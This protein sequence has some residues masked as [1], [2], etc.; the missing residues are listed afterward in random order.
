MA[1]STDLWSS[2]SV[3]GVALI[4]QDSSPGA[5]FVLFKLHRKRMLKGDVPEMGWVLEAN[6]IF[7]LLGNFSKKKRHIQRDFKRENLQLPT[8]ASAWISGP[9]DLWQRL[10]ARP[11]PPG[12]VQRDFEPLII[13]DSAPCSNS[14]CWLP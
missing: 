5:L 2:K 10:Q 1:C 13:L 6:Q 9:E 11:G 4:P 3:A 12:G 7:Q 8:P 14:F